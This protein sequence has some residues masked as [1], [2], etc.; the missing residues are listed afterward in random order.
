MTR[1]RPMEDEE[2]G[3]YLQV[4]RDAYVRDILGSGLMDR[5]DAETKVEADIDALLSEGPKTPD[6]YLYVIEDDVGSAVGYVWLARQRDQVG[7]PIAFVYDIWIH[8]G[9]RGRGLGRSAMVALEEEVRSLGLDRIHLNVFGH[10]TPAR[11]L[12]K[13]LG[14]TEYSVFMGKTL[15]D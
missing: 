7:K 11:R 3:P 10:N 13:S 4:L 1:L 9:S 12:Y 6:A 15:S 8:E 2:Y 5:A 14:Y